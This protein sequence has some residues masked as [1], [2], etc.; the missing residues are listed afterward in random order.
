MAEEPRERPK[1]LRV[2]RA[3]RVVSVVFVVVFW[4]V[5][6]VVV[7]LSRAECAQW[8]TR[9]RE[10][11]RVSLSEIAEVATE[12]E[13]V[14]LELPGALRGLALPGAVVFSAEPAPYLWVHEMAHQVQMRR[15]GVVSFSLRYVADWYRGRLN[16]CGFF[17]A[18]HAIGYEL[19]ADATARQVGASL[20]SVWREGSREA[21]VEALSEDGGGAWLGSLLALIRERLG[22][23]DEEEAGEE[24]AAGEGR[25]QGRRR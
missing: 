10:R 16:G 3:V 1:K 23:T 5:P 14:Q 13:T 12:V 9:P 15:D 8:E 17:D 20:R 7:V 18:Y 21:F 4:M 6:D 22:A 11:E 24:V 19:D 2:R 25:E